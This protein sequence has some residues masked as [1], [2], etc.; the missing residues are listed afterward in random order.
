MTM[1]EAI[2]LARTG[3]GWTQQQLADAVP[4]DQPTVSRWESGKQMPSL[5]QVRRIEDI[6]EQRR[7]FLLVA[8]GYIDPP[9]TTREWLEMDSDLDEGYRR[10]LLGVYD[11]A[12]AASAAARANTPAA[13]R[14]ARKS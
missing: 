8:A 3:P 12:V 11:D 1:G 7:G 4:I 2:A 6:T 9:K 10:V 13:K 5:E 14:R